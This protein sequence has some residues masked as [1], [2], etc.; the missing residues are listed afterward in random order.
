MQ[1][2]PSSGSAKDPPAR[3]GVHEKAARALCVHPSSLSIIWLAVYVYTQCFNPLRSSVLPR[4]AHGSCGHSFSC[5][6][7]PPKT[8][9]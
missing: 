2:G 5:K 8:I 1:K 4:R 9:S 3:D 6:D 7:G